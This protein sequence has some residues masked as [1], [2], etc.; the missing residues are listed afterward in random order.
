ME[1]LAYELLVYHR[2]GKQRIEQQ[3]RNRIEV[4]SR[5]RGKMT[6]ITNRSISPSDE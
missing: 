5:Q 3:K 2:T 4:R 1:D 6:G